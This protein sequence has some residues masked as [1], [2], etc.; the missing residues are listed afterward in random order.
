MVEHLD[1]HLDVDIGK[2]LNSTNGVNEDE[3]ILSCV[4]TPNCTSSNYHTSSKTCDVLSSDRF[5]DVDS[6]KSLTGATHFSIEV[7][8]NTQGAQL[9]CRIIKHYCFPC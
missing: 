6:F 9:L 8:A 3:C 2:I 7:L 5:R 4:S 1:M